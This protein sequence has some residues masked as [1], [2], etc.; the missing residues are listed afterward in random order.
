M[1]DA[2]GVVGGRP[3]PTTSTSPAYLSTTATSSLRAGRAA[4]RAPRTSTRLRDLHIAKGIPVAGGMAGGSADAAATLVALDRLWSLQHLRRRPAGPGRRARQRRAVRAGRRHRARHRPRRGGRP[5][6]RR[7]RVAGGGS[8]CPTTTGLSTPEV[9]AEFDARPRHRLR[10]GP[11]PDVGCDARLPRR[12]SRRLAQRPAGPGAPTCAPTS[13]SPATCSPTPAPTRC[14]SRGSGPTFLGLVRD[15][16][17]AHDVVERLADRGRARGPDRHRPGRRRARRGVRA[18]GEPSQP[19]AG[20]QGVRRA[21]AAHRRL[22]RHRRGR[23]DRHRRP[24]RRRQDHAARGDDRPRAAGQRPGLA[25]R[26]GC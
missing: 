5:A 4:R 25:V 9:Y 16:D 3:R 20:L 6:G 1:T 7:R 21:P 19:G 13:P 26:A 12:S 24:Q 17:A 15:R 8:W 10:H 22:P 11:A 2:D 23:A 14:C 18:S